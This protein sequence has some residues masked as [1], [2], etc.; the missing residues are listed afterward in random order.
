MYR[1]KVFHLICTVT[2]IISVLIGPLPAVQASGGPDNGAYIWEDSND[3]GGPAYNWQDISTTGTKIAMTN[4]SI[5]G[6]LELGFPFLFYGQVYTRLYIS[7]NGFV[8][9][10]PDQPAAPSP[11]AIPTANGPNAIIA[12]YWADLNPTISELTLSGLITGAVY[13]EV[14]GTSPNRIAIFQYSDVKHSGSNLLDGDGS[15]FQIKLFEGTNAIEIHYQSTGT[16]NSAPLHVAGIEDHTGTIGL[17]YYS[18]PGPI[19]AET[20]VRFSIFSGLA[21]RPGNQTLYGEPGDT[22]RFEQRVANWTGAASTFSLSTSGGT[23]PTG[24]TIDG[25]DFRTDELAQGEST[26][27]NVEVQIPSD[28]IPGEYSELTLLID[29]GGPY[30]QE[31][32]LIA[33]VPRVGYAIGY[34]G[35]ETDPLNA[36]LPV[37]TMLHNS[38]SSPVDI[39]NLEAWINYGTITP[40]GKELW[41]VD[42]MGANTL[43]FDVDNLTAPPIV[44]ATESETS[45][46]AFTPDGKTAVVT[47][48]AAST[49]QLVDTATYTVTDTFP[50]ASGP[51]RAAIGACFPNKA[52]ATAFNNRATAV[53]AIDLLKK[54]SKQISGFNLPAGVVVSPK[55]NRAFVSN[56]GNGTIGVINTLTDTLET[57]WNIGG[58]KLG[59]IDITPDGETLYV[60]DSTEVIVVDAD[61]GAVITRITL[62]AEN[63]W[64]I[65]AFPEGMGNF[66]YVT[67]MMGESNTIFVIDT[68]TN[69]LFKEIVDAWDPAGLA[70]FPYYRE[71]QA[72]PQASFEPVNQVVKLNEPV[73]WTNTSIYGATEYLWDFGDGTTSTETHPTHTYTAYG[74]YEVTLTAKNEHGQ[75][76]FKGTVNFAPTAAFEPQEAVIQPGDTVNFTNL[77]EGPG[78]LT[79]LWDFGDGSTS[80]EENPSHKYDTVG[81]YQVK[82]TVTN[83]YGSDTATGIVA[84]P[85]RAAF[86]PTNAI[87]KPGESVTFNNQTTGTAPISYTWDFGDSTTSTEVSPTHTF[88]GN[89]DVTVTLTAKGYGDPSTATGTVKFTPKAQFSPAEVTLTPGEALTFMDQSVG[90]GPFEYAWDFGDGTSADNP[91]PSHTY[92]T[93]KD[94]EVKL[95]VTNAN[96]SDTATGYVHFKPKAAFTQSA[97]LIQLGDEIQF[98]N[99]STGSGTLTYAW[100]FGDGTTSTEENPTHKYEKTGTFEVKLTV[101]NKYGSDTA[102]TMVGF[103]PKAVFSHPN[104][105]LL[106][107]AIVFENHSTGTGPLSYLWEFGDGSTSTEMSP[108]HT[109]AEALNYTVRLTVTNAY[110]SD[111]M[112]STISFTLNAAFTQSA[113]IIQT[114]DTITFT[115]LSTGVGPLIYHWDFGDG[116]TSE[117]KD[118]SHTY[119]TAGSYTVTLTVTRPGDKTATA[120]G[121]VR[122]RPKASIGTALTT[123]SQNTRLQLTSTSTGTA[124]MTYLWEFGDGTTS[125]AASPVHTYTKPGKYTIKLTVSNDYGTDTT[126]MQ[127]QVMPNIYLPF[128]A[129]R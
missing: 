113:E 53:T 106:G 54:Q 127:I 12:A 11:A 34:Y 112:E 100:D 86:T 80:T 20:A 72:A 117:E 14:V 45:D 30:E 98:T 70:L 47:N 88:S 8:T 2:F 105:V 82:L 57:T 43:V 85:A 10:L 79:Y 114:G 124:P 107:D 24:L 21:V 37:D 40:D 89:A 62:P 129:Y 75:S 48:F 19:E 56:S 59:M 35:P 118:P 60:V 39:D 28:A 32:K 36:I 33:A 9:F 23:W 95:T 17:P 63:L 73:S 83:E 55:T 52:Y 103:K 110:G 128:I 4:D 64:D 44:I 65:E 69:T 94:Y 81:D 71:C 51:V 61:T 27:I 91:N 111:T 49:A 38:L 125:N 13:Y 123:V 74:S 68:V 31:V 25:I 7:S 6:P 15:T 18:G 1:N 42:S 29:E 66:V 122:F 78:T 126:E 41:V 108:S 109:Y 116:A 50:T 119:T 76:T 84:F 3:P 90:P 121:Q 5:T 115:N 102:S 93:Y 96:G 26:Y 16:I 87:I 101:T 22:V 104:E 46:V 120:T 97:S 67:N 58:A 99:Q 77:S 92:T